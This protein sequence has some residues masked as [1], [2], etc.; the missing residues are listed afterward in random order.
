MQVRE[1]WYA[2]IKKMED[3]RTK[4]IDSRGLSVDDGG[5]I[6]FA[7]IFLSF[8]PLGKQKAISHTHQWGE[9]MRRAGDRT[10]IFFQRTHYP[11]AAKLQGLTGGQIPPLRL[12]ARVALGGW[13]MQR[14]VG[15][16]ASLLTAESRSFY[17]DYARY[18]GSSRKDWAPERPLALS[19]KPTFQREERGERGTDRKHRFFYLRFLYSSPSRPKEMTKMQWWGL[20]REICPDCMGTVATTRVKSGLQIIIGCCQDNKLQMMP[21]DKYTRAILN[22]AQR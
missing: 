12:S 21:A 11:H 3:G 2:R 1:K 17:L 9:N 13:V 5:E 10:N 15:C 18:D 22:L 16:L 14:R 8:F 4:K 6:L 20:K 7:P 19:G